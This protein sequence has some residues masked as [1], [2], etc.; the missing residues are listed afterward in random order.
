MVPSQKFGRFP[1]PTVS[2][3]PKKRRLLTKMAQSD[4]D[5]PDFGTLL[6]ERVWCKGASGRVQEEGCKWKGA[7]GRAQVEGY[8][9]KVAVRRDAVRRIGPTGVIGRWVQK[10]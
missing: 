2:N 9:C 5:L 7:S 3:D 10:G 1:L 8:R 4:S 6:T